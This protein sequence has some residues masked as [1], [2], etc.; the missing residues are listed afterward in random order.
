MTDLLSHLDAALNF[1]RQHGA[2]QADAVVIRGQSRSAMIRQ[3]KAEGIRH[4]E[5]LSLGLRVFHK[6]RVATV[7]GNE[8]S[9]E[10]LDQLAE[11][12]C[13]MARVVPPSPDDGLAAQPLIPV[14]ASTVAKLDLLDPATPPDMNA[15]LDRAR[16]MEEAALSHDGI[17]NSSGASASTSLQDVA[18][19][20]SAGFAGQYQRSGHGYGISVLAGTGTQMERDYAFHNAVHQAD[21][22]NP[23]RLGHEA[24]RRAL[25]RLNPT[26]PRTGLYPVL[27]DPRVAGSLLAHLAGAIN[28]AAIVQEA[29]FLKEKLNR[30]VFGR[31]ITITD[32]PTLPRLSGSR[33]FDGEGTACLPLNLVEDGQL[34]HWLLDSRCARRLNLPA[35]NGRA[36]RSGGG[37][38]R[39]G[40][41]NLFLHAG[42]H[43]PEELRHDI[44]EGVLVTELMGNAINM[45]TGD[46]SRGG[47]GFMIRNGEIAEPVS[48]ITIA[49]NLSDMFA[50]LI[51]AN[52][53]NLMA[54]YYAPTIRIDQMSLAGD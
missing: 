11:R 4:A 22:E 43:S 52:D 12:A 3:G 8:L 46:Y 39:P 42:P 29:S 10:A 2:D 49:G 53:L 9:P 30:T 27:F 33:P 19:A 50:R 5:S 41:S 45:L 24:A 48:G 40:T 17:T 6:G 34:R 54:G 14:P 51:P 44:K 36:S 21:L 18:L 28:G 35:S 20:T 32:D 47:S 26:R 31:G 38:V 1:A 25:A 13:A 37:T 7:S 15:L 23:A 16:D